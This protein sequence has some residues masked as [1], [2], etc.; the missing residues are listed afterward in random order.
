MS[1]DMARTGIHLELEETLSQTGPKVVDTVNAMSNAFRNLAD[2][3]T[4]VSGMQMPGSAGAGGVGPQPA[5]GGQVG[6][7]PQQLPGA[8]APGGGVPSSHTAAGRSW[9]DD[10]ARSIR[11][12]GGVIGRAGGGDVGGAATDML[13]DIQGMV[14]K[15]P[16]VG[17]IVAIL[18]A[19]AV[20]GNMLSKQYEQHMEK[21][22][23]VNN[24][25][26]RFGKTA[27]GTSEYFKQTMQEVS[28]SAAK[29]GYDLQ[30]GL[31]VYGSLISGG[32]NVGSASTV[33]GMAR[34]G[35]T[36]FNMDT[37]SRYSATASRFGMR[38]AG[39]TW[40]WFGDDMDATLGKSYGAFQQ[41]G[42]S[43]GLFDEFLHNTLAVFEEGIGRGITKGF[44]EINVT[45]NWLGK[46]GPAF[47]GQYGLQQYQ[48][49]NA[50]I[51]G[52]T[53]LQSEQQAIMYRAIRN[54]MGG[55]PGYQD[56]MMQLEQGLS[57]ANFTAIR[58]EAKSLTNNSPQ[59]MV[60]L[61]RSLFNVNYT[62][63]TALQQLPDMSDADM[64]KAIDALVPDMPGK[65]LQSTPE[66]R[67]LTATQQI[68]EDIRELGKDI[69]L[70]LK[71]DIV[72]G[73]KDIEQLLKAYLSGVAPQGD[74]ATTLP[75]G[76]ATS[77]PG[78]ANLALPK[79]IG[80]LLTAA[81]DKKNNDLYSAD[82]IQAATELQQTLTWVGSKGAPDLLKQKLAAAQPLMRIEQVLG[83]DFEGFTAGD[84]V[85]AND[86][87]KA[88]IRNLAAVLRGKNI[89][90]NL[91]AYMV[92]GNGQ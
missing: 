59:D 68:S 79:T 18:A 9:L 41:S 46:L 38:G 78:A 22:M 1:G 53:G 25:L 12:G 56:V 75:P 31:G 20:V 51:T 47:Q 66:M 63:A 77:V 72:V 32:G 65:N 60:E 10:L 3:M 8:M 74:A 43:K 58:N 80:A 5:P 19:T 45:Q 84:L 35:G 70:P 55:N 26:G 82:V 73:I 87:L 30:T 62:I 86:E 36:G 88:E 50:S 21:I 54:K 11:G 92:V 81:Q 13:G 69:A 48:S 29:F 37:M 71:T 7:Q 52:A 76:Y 34:Y 6:P 17:K 16:M 28:A 42:M 44:D 61:F 14:S 4:R 67:L 2:Q 24:A 23:E 83:Q 91:P 27:A 40:N 39:Q 85:L 57:P 33:M 89:E 64:K 90:V 15:I 49:M